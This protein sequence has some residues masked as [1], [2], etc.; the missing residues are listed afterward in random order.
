MMSSWYLVAFASQAEGHG[1]D[2]GGGGALKLALDGY[3]LVFQTY[4]WNAPGVER[5]TKEKAI[6]RGPGGS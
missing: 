5:S 4:R 3:S 2:P 1:F 6:L